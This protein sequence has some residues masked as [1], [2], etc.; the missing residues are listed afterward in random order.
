MDTI[1]KLVYSAA[2]MVIMS[3]VIGMA[4]LD[5]KVTRLK[6]ENTELKIN[7]IAL[8]REA[9]SLKFICSQVTKKKELLDSMREKYEN[10]KVDNTN[11]SYTLEL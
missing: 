3:L 7:S 1:D 6:A 5:S 4:V 2:A 9:T 8:E 10:T 11:G